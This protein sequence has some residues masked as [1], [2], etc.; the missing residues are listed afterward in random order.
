MAP[1]VAEP[2]PP[3]TRPQPGPPRLHREYLLV[4]ALSLTLYSTSVAPGPLWQDNGMAQVRALL[5]DLCGQRGLAL[6]HPLYYCIAWLFLQLPL[7]EPALRVNLVSVV[8]GAITA[9]N[10]YLLLRTL[11]GS[12]G[13]ASVG[14]LSLGLA[15]TFWQHC[16]MA[17]TYTLYTCTLSTELLLW[18]ACA[19]THAPRWLPWLFLVNGLGVSN[20]LLA[21]LDLAVFAACLL[22]LA[23]ARRLTPRIVALCALA[24]LAGAS[25]YL[26]L[27]IREMLASGA[28]LTVLHSALFGNYARNVLNLQLTPRLL[29]TGL[30]CLALNFPTPVV[31][32]APTGLLALRRLAPPPVATALPALLAVHL[33]WAIR[34]NIPDQYTFFIPTVL[35]TAVLIGL[36]AATLE[37]PARPLLRRL[38]LAG[39]LLPPIVYAL[40]PTLI[41]QVGLR[42]VL[43][44]RSV[45]FRDELRYYLW[46]WKTGYRGPQRF[47][48]ELHALLPDQAYLLADSTTAWPIHYARLTGRWKR[49]V[50]IWPPARYGDDREDR[51]PQDVAAWLASGRLLTIRPEPAYCPRWLLEGY[52]FEPF[53]FIYRVSAPRE[54]TAPPT[55]P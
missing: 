53:G 3:A 32:L 11:G 20:H 29:L 42:H 51:R 26:T 27:V 23:A 36:G 16:A 34:Y 19:R 12:R 18:T 41:E 21:L 38:I 44:A 1:R 52:T 50:T 14:T 55:T 37:P 2:P 54:S 47:V 48:A 24:W 30:L 4:L 22:W 10:V 25:L 40:L 17:E 49:D 39:C 6:S 35:L 45:P 33:L 13:S 43:L 31:L 46:P 7:G 15:H 28:I 8:F 5:G 9:A